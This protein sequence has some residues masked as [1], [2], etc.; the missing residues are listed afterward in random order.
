MNY[1][2]VVMV[3]KSSL[4]RGILML[5]LFVVQIVLNIVSH[6]RGKDK[7]RPTHDNQL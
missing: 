2:F 6:P 3:W 5:A 4:P 1:G 7:E